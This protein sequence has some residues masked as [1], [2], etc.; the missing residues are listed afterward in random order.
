MRISAELSENQLE[1][2]IVDNG[3]GIA[4]EKMAR[5]NER[6]RNDPLA[7]LEKDERIGLCNVGMRLRL[8]YGEPS[9]LTLERNA[10]G[11]LTVY[12]RILYPLVELD[13][14]ES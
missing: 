12:M 14:T 1:I 6:L 13:E 8:V 11:G 10:M 3:C 9:G 4:E 2:R 7:K 5:L